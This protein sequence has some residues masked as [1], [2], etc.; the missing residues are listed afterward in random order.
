MTAVK[1]I[2]RTFLDYFVSKGHTE[3]SSSSLVP[4]NDPTMMFV[5]SGMVQFKNVFTGIDKRPYTR[6]TTAQKC[7]R[8]GGKHNDLENVGYT[9]RHHTFFEMLGNFSFGD[10]FKDDAIAFAWELVT[11]EFGLPADKLC[12]TVH[13]SDEEAAEIWKKVTGFSDN[14]IIRIP[15][16][17]NFWR[18]GDTGPCGPCTEIFYD[19]GDHIWGGPPGSAEEDGD[20][21]IEIWNNVFMQYEQLP[22]RKIDLPAQS[23]DTGMGLER[24]AA[25]LQGVHT[26]YEIDIFQALIGDIANKLSTDPEN[27][28]QK[29]SHQVIADHLRST[30]F[31]MADGVMPSNDGRGYVLRRIMRRAMRHAHILGAQDPLMYRLV[32]EL[33]KQMGEAYPE[34]IAAQSL[35]NETL[36]L[37]ETRFK[38]TLERGLSMLDEESERLGEGGTLEGDKAFRLY[39]TFGFPI[40]LT[41]D[42]LKAKNISVDM[43]GFEKSMADA[44]A[45]ARAS[46]AG[47]GDEANE[48][49]WFDVEDKCGATEFLGYDKET[50]EAQILAIVKD[51]ALVDNLAAGET[52]FVI[53][54]QTPFY[55]ESGGQVGDTGTIATDEGAKAMVTDT[56][57]KLCKIWA[58][59]INVTSGNL[60]ANDSAA[61]AIDTDRRNA[62]RGNH[63]ATHLLHEALRQHLGDHVAQ[64]GSLQ[65]DTRTRFDIS[66][67]KSISK[68]EL[69]KITADVIAEIEANTPVVTR[70]MD[71]DEAKGSGARALFGEKYDSEVRVVSMGR[72]T[73]EH[74]YSV[75]LCGGTHVKK[76]GDIGKFM[77]VAESA[78][79]AGVRRIEAITGDRVDAYLAEKD[80]AIKLELDHLRAQFDALL[81][82]LK[83][84]GGQAEMCGASADEIRAAN[85]AIEKQIADLRRAQGAET[86]D[87]DIKT[88]GSVKYIGKV[89]DGFAPQDLKPMADQLKSKIGSGVIALVATNDGKASIVVGVTQDLT[90]KYNAVELVKIGSQA[91]GGNGG[92]GRPDMAQAGGPNADAANDAVTSIEA[93]LAG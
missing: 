67:P 69:E 34:L 35:M 92:G 56:K 81:K 30:C 22:D 3:V 20:R 70:I 14:K 45:K 88:I 57:K 87:K 19:H 46:W 17:D 77:I 93:K 55:A 80:N 51:G 25:I 89:L 91:L 90:D 75:E 40:D 66:H 64:K 59:Q 48:T 37:E 83:M 49:I 13:T 8:A 47:S 21:F 72:D 28:K 82:D 54:N 12:V 63:S 26:N 27:E 23:V 32:P 9:A 29:A 15:T 85:R 24:I 62:I 4:Q 16:D 74:A 50:C 42:A 58:H 7:V 53:V 41:A 5:N 73:G 76:T 61:L 44:K 11:K 52:G 2:R 60:H 65:D 33:I 36:K 78:V 79:S 43:E 39:D 6:A 71:L 1:D 68:D 18:M 31:L 84:L 10:Y 38:T 86:S